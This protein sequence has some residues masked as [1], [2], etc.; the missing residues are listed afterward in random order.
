[1]KLFL[2]RLLII[3]ALFLLFNFV[4]LWPGALLIAFIIEYIIEPVIVTKI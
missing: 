1:M 2:L 3:A 4:L